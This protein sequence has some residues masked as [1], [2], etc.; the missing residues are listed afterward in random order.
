MLFYKLWNF[1]LL[2]FCDTSNFYKKTPLI[3]FHITGTM[4]WKWKWYHELFHLF[5][6]KTILEIN[7]VSYFIKNHALKSPKMFKKQKQKNHS[8][9]QQSHFIILQ[10]HN[11]CQFLFDTKAHFFEKSL[12]ILRLFFRQ[13]FCIKRP[14]SI[15]WR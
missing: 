7:K 15:I 2:T 13:K 6:F 4:F 10:F 8:Y 14:H 12:F 5:H 3:L 1:C 11:S 9:L